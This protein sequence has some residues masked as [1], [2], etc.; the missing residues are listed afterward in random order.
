MRA[1][2]PAS[3]LRRP[4]PPLALGILA[5]VLCVMAETLL[6]EL[7]TQ[8]APVRSLS[9]LYLLGIVLVASL[10]GLR[11]GMATAMVS[12]IAFDHFVIP[13]SGSFAVA[14]GEDWA[15]LAVFSA[16]TLVTGLISKLARSLAVE[17]DARE[18]ADLCANLARVL[19][20]GPDLKTAQPAAAQH[21]A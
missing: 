20:R 21:L 16:V 4:R 5:A 19:L 7:L 14:K 17:V 6:A 18:E 13:P 1:G 10:W 3:L 15:M 8:I 9:V 2:L 11:L 12:I